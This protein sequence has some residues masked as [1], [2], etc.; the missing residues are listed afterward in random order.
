MCG[1]AGLARIDGGAL[2][3]EVLPLLENM[4]RLLAHRGPDGKRVYADDAVGLAFTRLSIVDPVGG[5]Q[6]LSNDDGSTIVIANGEIYNHRELEASLPAGTRMKTGS[7]CE[8]LVHLYDRDGLGFLDDVRGIYAIVLWDRRRRRLVFAR[9][10]FGIKP[11]YYSRNA[12]R[13]VFGSEIKALFADPATP[14]EL[15][16]EQCLRDQLVTIAPVFEDSDPVSWFKG[17]EVVPAGTIRT[18]DVADGT[19]SDHRYWT[20][21][22]AAGNETAMAPAEIIE[23]YRDLLAASVRESGMSDAE[24]GLF[25]SGGIDSAAV[26]AFSGDLDQLHTFTALNGATFA[27]GDGEFAHRVATMLG[28]PNHQVAFDVERVPSVDEWKRLLWLLETPLCG[29]E[30]FYKYELHRFARAT[31]P[32]LK[33][34]LLGQASDEFNGGYS[35]E[36]AGGQGWDEAMASI[37]TLSRRRAL[38]DAPR[39]AP[40]WDSGL[41]L[42]KDSVLQGDASSATEPYQEYLRW[43]F[44][45]IQQY[46][47]WHEDR[48]AAGNGVEAR[49]P[50]LDHR[51]VELTC[52]IP[53]SLRPE[54]LW[55]KRILREALRGV[56]PDYLVDRPKVA[57]FYGDGV[58]HVYRTFTRMLTQEG[59]ALIEEAVAGSVA[60][61]VID[62]DAVRF[63]LARLAQAPGSTF[64]VE[65]LLQLVNLGLMERMLS[66]IPSPPS[67][68]EPYELPVEIRITDWDSE[69]ERI[70]AALGLRDPLPSDLVP[71]FAPG[72]TLLR[73]E[74]RDGTWYL[75]LNGALEYEMTESDDG[76]WLTF[77]RMVDGRKSLGE[78]ITQS[79]ARPQHI[80][81][82]VLEAFD[83]GAL[84]EAPVARA[85]GQHP[86][87]LELG[88]S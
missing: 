43:K 21:P 75:A 57:F 74:P 42:L 30:Q 86:E 45:D 59:G 32:N 19:T 11:L 76:E 5:D 12:E 88:V 13:V 79:R 22:S 77:L 37:D 15:D 68:W 25:L 69:S 17:I 33:V 48:T 85:S 39:L 60:A 73:A 16:W 51:L 82:L 29:P 7:D 56:L 24:I 3:D 66:S 71:V 34:M 41:P 36:L 40:W 23:R 38:F 27:N 52:S 62:A 20:L 70:A 81:A 61:Q 53:R 26:A 8:V 31:Q 64:G 6:P 1:L 84:T 9:D 65:R 10:R 83:V 72:V 78:L 63:T 80:Y 87:I 4:A 46:N 50:F 54:L 14:R 47:C 55:D 44:R 58:R 2:G 35:W 18:I 28:R 49:V 67:T